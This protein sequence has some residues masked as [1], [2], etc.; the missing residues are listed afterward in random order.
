MGVDGAVGFFFV[1]I[2]FVLEGGFVE[3]VQEAFFD[4]AGALEAPLRGDELADHF[5]GGFVGGLVEVGIGVGQALEFVR[6]LAVQYVPFGGKAVEQ[7]VRGAIAF[8]LLGFG[9][10]GF[11]GI[12]LICGDLLFGRHGNCPP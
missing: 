10:G 2:L 3:V 9:A 11:P 6:V 12:P 1:V 8:S 5:G 4:E 7:G